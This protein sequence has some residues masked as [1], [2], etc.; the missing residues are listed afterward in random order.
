LH[1]SRCEFKNKDTRHRKIK[2]SSNNP[3]FSFL[4]P[5]KTLSRNR[6]RLKV[7][8][9][10]NA[11][12]VLSGREILSVTDLDSL[13]RAT[14]A[15]GVAG[16]RVLLSTG[17]FLLTGFGFLVLLNEIAEC[18][19][20]SAEDVGDAVSLEVVLA[21]NVGTLHGLGDP[22]ETD[23]GRGKEEEALKGFKTLADERR[24]NSSR[25][26]KLTE[27]LMASYPSMLPFLRYLWWVLP[28][29]THGQQ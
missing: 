9:E 6:L 14:I 5:P 27:V 13:L 1:T 24:G 29:V 19:A 12:E 28:K 7:F 22:V 20:A 10:Q 4:L 18:A 25:R 16:L 15:H 17:E 26:G 2:S 21:A 23:A 11:R 3:R 8:A